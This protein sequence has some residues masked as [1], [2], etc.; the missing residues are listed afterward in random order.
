VLLMIVGSADTVSGGQRGLD[1]Y[2]VEEP[3]GQV[4]G[5]WYGRAV[6]AMPEA[7]RPKPREETDSASCGSW[8]ARHM[9]DRCVALTGWLPVRPDALRI[10]RA[11]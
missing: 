5:H 7:P 10:C 11:G 3:L 2:R 1:I 8:A 4:S 6:H 9:V